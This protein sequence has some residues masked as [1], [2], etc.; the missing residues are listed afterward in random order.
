MIANLAGQG[1]NVS[2]LNQG[3]HSQVN[4]TQQTQQA[5][6]N[7]Q[8]AQQQMNN[9]NQNPHLSASQFD[10]SALLRQNPTQQTIQPVLDFQDLCSSQHH[11]TH[12][13]QNHALKVSM[14][15]TTRD[16]DYLRNRFYTEYGCDTNDIL[17]LFSFWQSNF[18][19]AGPGGMVSG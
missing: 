6:P 8:A 10:I 12:P 16:I 3:N 13:N 14:D 15:A 11:T 9:N 18:Q 19:L 2:S 17:T 7:L 1:Q 4:F 5:H